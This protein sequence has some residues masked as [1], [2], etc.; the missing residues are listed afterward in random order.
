[1]KVNPKTGDPTDGYNTNEILI[2]VIVLAGVIL[3]FVEWLDKKKKIMRGIN[4]L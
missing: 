2:A 1:V 4:S 3:F